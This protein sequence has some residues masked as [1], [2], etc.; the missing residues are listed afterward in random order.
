MGDSGTRDY[1]IAYD[2]SCPRR[3][4]RIGRLCNREAMRLQKSLYHAQLSEAG[5]RKLAERLRL[6]IDESADDLRFYTPALSE[7]MSWLGAPAVP[8]GVIYTG[9]AINSAHDRHFDDA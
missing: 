6:E 2:I 7:P 5:L 8:D 1:L 4:G 3:L 9:V